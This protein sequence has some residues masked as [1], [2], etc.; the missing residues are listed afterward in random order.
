M[1]FLGDVWPDVPQLHYVEFFHGVPG[2]DNDISDRFA[3]SQSWEEKARARIKNAHLLS[4]LNQMQL[5]ICPTMFQ[6]SLLPEW[7]Q[8][9]TKI[10]HDGINTE[11][12]CPDSSS[13]LKIRKNTKLKDGLVLRHG[14]PVITFVNR[15]FE[16]YRGVHV[17]LEALAHVQSQHPT[18]NTVLIGADTPKVSYG[19]RRTDDRGW[20]TALREEMGSKLDWNRIHHLG[21]VPHK[22]L[23]E[24]YR[25]SQ[26]HVYLTYPFVVS[27]AYSKQ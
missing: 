11:W 9:R 23:R 1:L 20:L 10:I 26:A 3:T 18:A 5:G 27:G 21:Q 7:A 2:T 16:P 22:I 14:D 6:H 15:T 25:V 12:L 17:F 8:A 4:N 24:V 19:A 13:K